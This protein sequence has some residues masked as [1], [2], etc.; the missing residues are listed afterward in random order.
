MPNLMNELKAEIVRLARKE[1]KKEMAP[2]RK[3]IVA[4]R[5]LIADLRRQVNGMQ[6]EL[7]AL[8]KS[9]PAL[10]KDVLAKQEPE[11]RFWITGKG[12]KAL[13]TRLGLT[14][15]QFAGLAGVS[16]QAVFLWERN[17]GK[18]NLRKAAAGKLQGLRGIGKRQAAEMLGQGGNK[19]KTAKRKS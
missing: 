6:K 13:R 3:S 7:N 4:Q 15:Q 1:L 17:K 12:V 5:G 8:K 2:A 10:D 16:G 11:G 14:Q 9:A 19:A 18:V